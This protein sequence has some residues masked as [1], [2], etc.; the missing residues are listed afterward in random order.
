M[1]WLA[2]VFLSEPHI[3]HRLGNLLADLVRGPQRDL[4]GAQF[5]RGAALHR[6]IDAYTDAHPIVRRSRLRLSPDHRRFS[7]VLIDI[8]YDHLLASRWEQYSPEPLARF[9]QHFYA[10]AQ[11]AQLALPEEARTTLER[12]IRHDLLGAYARIDGVEESLRRLS[13]YLA[14]RWRREFALERSIAELREQEPALA[15]DFAEFFP[16]LQAHTA[17][18]ASA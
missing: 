17:Q 13:H 1:N 3:E 4:M 15:A 16:G 10:Q 9:T 7:G 11:E 8:F 12:I 14:R 2:H 18:A 6:V 5:R